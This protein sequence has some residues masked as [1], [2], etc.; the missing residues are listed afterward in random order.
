MALRKEEF[1]YEP[2]EHRQMEKSQPRKRQHITIDVSTELSE[3]IQVAAQQHNLSASQYIE[4]L[5][6]ETIPKRRN[7]EQVRKPITLE[8]VEKL[9][10]VREQLLRDHGGKPFENSIELL[11]REREEREKELGL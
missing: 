6:E 9:M 8:D 7:A 5:L 4:S 2:E 11:H 1:Y 3:R 10:Q